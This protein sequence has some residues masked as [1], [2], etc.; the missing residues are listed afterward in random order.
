MLVEIDFFLYM[1]FPRIPSLF[2]CVCVCLYVCVCMCVCVCVY[3]SF[4]FVIIVFLNS[5]KKICEIKK[6]DYF[7]TLRLRDLDLNP[8]CVTI[9][10]KNL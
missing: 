2:V 9:R 4:V 3:Y 10:K 6:N 8:C 5:Q 7:F 1:N